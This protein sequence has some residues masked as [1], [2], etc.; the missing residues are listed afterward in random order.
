MRKIIILTICFLFLSASLSGEVLRELKV[1]GLNKT[2]VS[3][4]KGIIGYDVGDVIKPE[5]EDG[6]RQDLLKSGLFIN[7]SI[8][9]D[10]TTRGDDAY[11][12]IFLHDRMTLL[13]IPIASIR[14][15]SFSGGL[16]VMDR[17]F[18]GLGH[19]LFAGG[20][21]SS[22][23][24]MFML[25][26][27]NPSINRSS[28]RIGGNLNGFMAD[29]KVTDL[30]GREDLAQYEYQTVGGS[31]SMGWESHPFRLGLQ[32]R[33]YY[34][35]VSFDDQDAFVFNPEISLEYNTF[36]Y[37]T[38]F[39]KGME[40]S[41]TF[42]I[43]SYSDVFDFTQSGEIKISFHQLLHERWQI[44]L[45]GD[46]AFSEGD[47]LQSL[48]LVHGAC[49]S[50][51]PDTVL[52]DRYIQGNLKLQYAAMDFSWGYIA[53]PLAYQVGIMDGISGE[54]ALFHGPSAGLSFFLKR[55]AIPAMSLQYSSNLETGKGLFSFNIGMEM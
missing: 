50:I 51:L 41:I 26:Y 37:D 52:A 53:V 4:I 42:G 24:R 30:S 31:V 27:S 21:A 6:I 39:N 54:N 14:E 7:E 35:D 23:N 11:L 28:Y 25:G 32:S 16:F 3:T 33:I 12:R 10:L 49:G 9:V 44:Q 22:E 55:V 29:E 48:S 15:G 47:Q 5:G 38:Y 40:S 19:Q 8:E 46:M 34:L 20:M 13:P 45:N 18:L 1:V 17:N 36:Y 43:K 2:R